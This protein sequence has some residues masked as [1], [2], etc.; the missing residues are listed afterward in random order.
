MAGFVQIVQMKT[1]RVD[2][3]RQV[4]EEMQATRQARGDTNMPVRATMGEDRDRPGTYI[5]IIEF[6]SYEAAM[7]SSNDPLTSEMAK[8]MAE[9]CEGPPTFTNINVQMVWER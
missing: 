8:K 5:S 2:E 9:L 4:V 3:V 1:S 7:A 6:D